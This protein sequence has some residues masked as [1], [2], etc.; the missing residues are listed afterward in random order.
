M[1]F[2]ESRLRRIEPKQWQRNDSFLSPRAQPLSVPAQVQ[3]SS[4][5]PLIAKPFTFIFISDCVNRLYTSLFIFQSNAPVINTETCEQPR[6]I[7]G[8][9]RNEIWCSYIHTQSTANSRER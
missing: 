7:S 1:E 3:L 4:P 8:I 2:L 9:F 6:D 5:S